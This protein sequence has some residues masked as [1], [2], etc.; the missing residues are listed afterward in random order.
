[1]TQAEVT[2]LDLAAL[3]GYLDREVPGLLNGQL[4]GR[5]IAGGR[6]NLTYLVTDGRSTWVVRRPP[7]GHV[8]E[9]AHDM[10]REHRVMAGL[11]GTDVPVPEMVAL[12]RDPAVLGAPFYVMSYVAGP[13]F[14][15]RDQLAEL[16]PDEAEALAAGL[17]DVLARLHEADPAAVGLADV[18]RP[19]GYLERQVRRWGKQLEAS[20]SRDVEDLEQLGRRL[21]AGVPRSKR[22]A[23]VHG[24]YKLDNVVV[25]PAD[26]GRI[27]AV[28]DWEMATLGD[29]MSDL[30]NLALWWD[31]VRDV[32]GQAFAAVPA[33]VPG[34]PA[35]SRLLERYAT[36]TGADLDDLP[37]YFALACYKL[38]AIFEG[39][40]YRDVQGLT[41]GDGFDRLAGL[42]PALARRGHAS[43]NEGPA[44]A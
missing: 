1:M 33:E 37:W 20:R 18:G 44:T 38:A 16:D 17:V 28:L 24:D 15:T 9:T 14:R 23:L 3:T 36:A 10:G 22:V 11:A 19:D 29:P 5:L 12:C 32:S 21:A 4:T 42:P 31:G 35:S 6:S 26:R 41:V 43:L 8:L 25:D 40:Y 34:F 2:G 7:L 13:V 39:M 27:L 30:V